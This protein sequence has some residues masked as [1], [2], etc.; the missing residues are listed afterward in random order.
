LKL[1]PATSAQFYVKVQ[2]EG[3]GS[4]TDWIV[5]ITMERG[6]RFVPD[7]RNF[8]GW[9]EREG[10]D[11][12]IATWMARGSDDSIGPGLHR[13]VLMSSLG[14]RSIQAT[15]SIRANRMDERTGRIQVAIGDDPDRPQTVTV[16]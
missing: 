12:W 14:N 1:D 7:D 3:A 6:S 5:V 11:A 10:P 8:D 15:Y 16:T 13:D 2:N 9:N 4:A